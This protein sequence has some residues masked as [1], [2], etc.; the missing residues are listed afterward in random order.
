MCFDR[1]TRGRKY[2]LLVSSLSAARR[3]RCLL[4]SICHLYAVL[5]TIERPMIPNAKSNRC[6]NPG[7]SYVKKAKTH[8]SGMADAATLDQSE[9]RMPESWPYRWSSSSRAADRRDERRVPRDCSALR[10]LRRCPAMFV[11]WSW[12]NNESHRSGI[13]AKICL[14]KKISLSVA[15]T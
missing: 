9:G 2:I 5:S 10:L 6:P 3:L 8:L 11:S 7:E 12:K 13:P 15:I 14:A 4:L 1:K